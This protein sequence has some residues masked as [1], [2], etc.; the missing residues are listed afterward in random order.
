[1]TDRHDD[2]A[3]R[4]HNAAVPRA[5]RESAVHISWRHA[6]AAECQAACGPRTIA[7]LRP[8][9]LRRHEAAHVD[10]RPPLGSVRVQRSRPLFGLPSAL[11]PDRLA[12]PDA[13]ARWSTRAV[14]RLHLVPRAPG[15]RAARLIPLR[16]RRHSCPAFG[17]G[18]G[19]SVVAQAEP[20]LG[21]RGRTPRPQG[22]GRQALPRRMASAARSAP[23]ATN[24]NPI[25]VTSCFVISDVGR[26][27]KTLSSSP[28]L[29]AGL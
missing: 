2:E 29:S 4:Q 5:K 12:P 14:Q 10:D 11:R 20:P 19:R 8:G 28:A 25:S 3:S 9:P 1:M 7:R 13:D 22:R 21:G 17:T 16:L 6:I 18:L 27:A 26:L 23:R 15:R 24:P